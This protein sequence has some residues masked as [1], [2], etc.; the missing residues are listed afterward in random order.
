MDE[1]DEG[2]SLSWSH[3]VMPGSL[4]VL[5]Y[6]IGNKVVDVVMLEVDDDGLPK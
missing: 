1:P 6:S 3:T 2:T 5:V 4:E